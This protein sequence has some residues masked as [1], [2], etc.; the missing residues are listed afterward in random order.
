[1]YDSRP[2]L[3]GRWTP[4]QKSSSPKLHFKDVTIVVP[5]KG[6]SVGNVLVQ[7]G[8]IVALGAIEA[9]ASVIE[10]VEGK[11]RLLTPGLIDIHTHGILNHLY[12]LGREELLSGGKCLA[13]FGVTTVIPTIVPQIAPGW[14][15]KITELAQAISDVDGVNVPGLH[16]EGPFMAIKGTAA[17]T[18]TGDLDLLEEIITACQGKLSVM[19]LSPETP[20]ILPII[21]RLRENGTAVFI[22]HTRASV[23]QAEA[24]FAAGA[25]HATHF[26][27]VFYSPPE[28]DLGVRPVGVVEAVLADRNVTVDF[29]ADGIHVHPA[30]IRA[31]VA[32]KGYRGV[33]LITDS[34][35]GAGLPPAVYDTPWGFQVR[36]REG[37]APR[38]VPENHLAGSGLTMDRGM[39]NLLQWLDLPQE[40]VWAMGTS[41]PAQV[42]GLKH[43]GRME[44]G[45]DADLVLWEKDMRPGLT[46]VRGKRVYDRDQSDTNRPL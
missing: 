25:S 23:E 17:P 29:I 33:T 46:W 12:A 37:D 14:L 34:I 20:G 16:L 35:I 36:V 32:A 26:Y 42:I 8:R 3:S 40:Q 5:G 21:R 44:V 11:G 27:D 9:T 1:M 28:T 43:T 10:C 45:A 24:T 19:S 4:D 41:N 18:L 31:A 38:Q 15:E 30:A 7:D 39:V 6:I 22:T 2:S 13:R